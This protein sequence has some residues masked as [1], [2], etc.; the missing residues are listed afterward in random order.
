MTTYFLLF[1][2]ISTSGSFTCHDLP[3]SVGIRFRRRESLFLD[4]N[5]TGRASLIAIAELFTR[6]YNSIIS[7]C[8]QTLY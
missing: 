2:I 7:T 8:H 4:Q 3:V 1:F 5:H 6:N